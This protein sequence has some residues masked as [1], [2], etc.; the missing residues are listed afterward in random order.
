MNNSE[1]TI[2]SESYLALLKH[3][4]SQ[5]EAEKKLD[6]SNHE[7]MGLKRCE[8]KNG[9]VLWMCKQHIEM[10]NPKIL[11]FNLKND[12]ST[13]LNEQLAIQMLHDIEEIK[14]DIV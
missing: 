1:E 7:V 3:F 10:T 11:E 4:S 8:M 6:D 5:L 9:K 13:N 14:I 12:T 2:F